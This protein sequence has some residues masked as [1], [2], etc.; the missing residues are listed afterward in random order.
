MNFLAITSK[1]DIFP[2]LVNFDKVICIKVTEVNNG[3]A[4][5]KI[6]LENGKYLTMSDISADSYARIMNAIDRG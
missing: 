6:E 2:D 4:T 1:N 3:K 5:L